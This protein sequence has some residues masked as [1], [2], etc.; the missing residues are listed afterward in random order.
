MRVFLPFPVLLGLVV[1]A[2]QAKDFT[3]KGAQKGYQT[4]IDI[5]NDVFMFANYAKQ[6]SLY[7][8]G[9]FY[10][11]DNTTP[12]ELDQNGNPLAAADSNGQKAIITWAQPNPDERP[13]SFIASWAGQGSVTLSVGYLVAG[14]VSSC[15]GNEP[16]GRTCDNTPCNSTKMQGY[17]SANIL[18]ILPPASSQ[19]GS[20]ALGVGQ[21]VTV[22][23]PIA[24]GAYNNT[25]GQVTLVS[26]FNFGVG[27]NTK[28]T[29]TGIGNGAPGAIQKLNIT[30]VTT[31]PGTGDNGGAALY[32]TAPAGLCGTSAS[33]LQ[34]TGNGYRWATQ[35][36]V[37]TTELDDVGA[38]TYIIGTAGSSN[39]PSCTGTGGAGTYLLNYS[40][41][42]GSSRN[43]V[44]F[45]QGERMVYTVTSDGQNPGPV[46]TGATMNA[47]VSGDR[48]RWF[49]TYQA[50]DEDNYIDQNLTSHGTLT[51]P[52]WR[53]YARNWTVFR[54][55]GF[56][57]INDRPLT[58]PNWASVKPL[59]YIQ[60]A[61]S[62]RKT[63]AYVGQLGIAP[64]SSF[65]PGTRSSNGADLYTFN[66]WDS[67]LTDGKTIIATIPSADAPTSTGLF[68]DVP[69]HG[70]TLGDT[71][72]V[73]AGVYK[74]V[75]VTDITT[76]SATG[77]EIPLIDVKGGCGDCS[78]AQSRAW[79]VSGHGYKSGDTLS[80]TLGGVNVT[81]T[82]RGVYPNAMLS[83]DGG[84]TYK[85]IMTDD[86]MSPFWDIPI[87][88]PI[89]FTYDA[90]L[91][92][93][94]AGTFNDTV[95]PG[96]ITGRAGGITGG[97]QQ[98]F[99]QVALESNVRPWFVSPN[100]VAV[101]NGTQYTA[102]LARFLKTNYPTL[103]PYF[104][105][106][107]EVWNSSFPGWKYA[108]DKAAVYHYLDANAWTDSENN[109]QVYG[110]AMSIIGQ[111]VAGVYGDPSR[112]DIVAGIFTFAGWRLDQAYG[113]A[114][115]F[116]SQDW[117]N[118]TIPVPSGISQTPA[119]KYI[120][121][122]AV[123][124]YEYP[125]WGMECSNINCV[126][127][128][129]AVQTSWKYFSGSASDRAAAMDTYASAENFELD[130]WDQQISN[131]TQ[132]AASCGD[133][134]FTI[135][136]HVT[137]LVQYEG[138]QNNNGNSQQ[139]AD[140]TELVIG[141]TPS[142]SSCV[143]SIG[144]QPFWQYYP[145]Y[146]GKTAQLGGPIPNSTYQNGKLANITVPGDVLNTNPKGAGYSSNNSFGL[147]PGAWVTWSGGSGKVTGYYPDSLLENTVKLDNIT[148]GSSATTQVPVQI[149]GTNAAVG[150]STLQL[151]GA[152]GGTWGNQSPQALSNLVVS[153]V[154]TGP[155][156]ANVT[157]SNLD[158]SSF[159]ALGTASFQGSVNGKT[160]TVSS[161][162]SGSLAVGQ[163]IIGNS[164]PPGTM[165][166]AGSG[167]SWTLSN[168][169]S[170]GTETME[171]GALLTYVGSKNWVNY[172]FARS[173]DEPRFGK[174]VTQE[175]ENFD[176]ARDAGGRPT[177][178]ANPSYLNQFTWLDGKWAPTGAFD[179]FGWVTD[180]AC[181]NCT[182]ANVTNSSGA[183]VGQITLGSA[184]WGVF[185]VGETLMG[186]GIEGPDD[187]NS[188]NTTITACIPSGTR[189]SSGTPSPC[190]SLPGDVLTLSQ[191]VVAGAVG[192]I[193]YYGGSPP[194]VSVTHGP[195]GS[196]DAVAKWDGTTYSPPN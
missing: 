194:L 63:S 146:F 115:R 33:A 187:G 53:Q 32:Y 105:G 22:S 55:L 51:S 96:A 172:M 86:Y 12:D 100:Y 189:P 192:T 88:F 147:Y 14:N 65:T 47:S 71:T 154:Y 95:P 75:Q 50:Q 3:V 46:Y 150:M 131:N 118:Q 151:T 54:D 68:A 134:T 178:N 176:R 89:S 11:N 39:C 155:G 76:P 113:A 18:T 38:P 36:E 148:G 30:N 70:I 34:C 10:H 174:L 162:T 161:I 52:S 40:Q 17:I 137:G 152:T 175:A 81:A 139:Q 153:A 82:V 73:P 29:V 72:N 91:D 196:L 84:T 145:L 158:C 78:V 45:T 80:M 41:T 8:T 48:L 4:V 58:T 104:E 177:I 121:K 166:T 57:Y 5:Q 6:G 31:G 16:D 27:P 114:P 102:Q 19:T 129:Q 23:V 28:V 26:A 44:Y 43:P 94:I 173:I 132:F 61:G 120:T 49:A 171:S 111:E 103:K 7:G 165:I 170:V 122:A 101:Y 190:G 24:S 77:G 109:D 90:E 74:D 149:W 169:A 156:Y 124:Y 167:S 83:I 186:F 179:I 138:G 128:E 163:S 13:G 141:A 125:K 15:V 92:V 157:I 144:P 117:V 20:C 142:G 66:W 181:F 159:R 99:A 116:Q 85:P 37:E 188:A 25:T 133:P 1:G 69:S 60:A 97:N 182:L 21:P 168:S 180:G 108:Y 98:F 64:G 183:T 185:R 62:Y 56:D 143:L 112:Y 93:W 35:G 193:T 87:N 135:E 42:V 107:N 9:W 160:L 79:Y 195:Q 130:S 191:P 67:S 59:T 127:N 2:A 126:N 123:T 106:P 164:I 110:K 184:N 136:C 119:N 140:S